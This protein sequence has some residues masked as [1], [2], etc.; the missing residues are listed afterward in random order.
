MTEGNAQFDV[1]DRG[2]VGKKGCRNEF[3]EGGREWYDYADYAAQRNRDYWTRGGSE[4][5]DR[6][7]HGETNRKRKTG[8]VGFIY[9]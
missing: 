1:K 7:M 3:K 9:L 5:R 8:F 4:P 2:S 6:M